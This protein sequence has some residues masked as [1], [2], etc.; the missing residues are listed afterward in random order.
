M[1]CPQCHEWRDKPHCPSPSCAWK[2]CTQCNIDISSTGKS[3]KH[4]MLGTLK[5][6]RP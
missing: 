5:D 3:I 6:G 2:W 4:V 1:M